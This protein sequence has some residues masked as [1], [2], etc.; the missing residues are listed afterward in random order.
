MTENEVFKLLKYIGWQYLGDIF[1]LPVSEIGK[2]LFYS[3]QENQVKTLQVITQENEELRR[4]LYNVGTL[5][6][7]SVLIMTSAELF[8][9]VNKSWE[10]NC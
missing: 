8:F 6:L 3:M 4:K 7:I 10:K 1:N 2:N 9:N 5:N